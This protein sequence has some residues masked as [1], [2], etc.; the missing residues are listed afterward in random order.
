MTITLV[1]KL[2]NLHFNLLVNAIH[3][4]AKVFVSISPGAKPEKS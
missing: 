4:A 2:V 3:H 1:I